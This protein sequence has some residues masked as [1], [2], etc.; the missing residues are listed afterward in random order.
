MRAPSVK[1]M[2]IVQCTHIHSDAN[3]IY[4]PRKFMWKLLNIYRTYTIVR[5][6]SS[7]RLKSVYLWAIF[8]LLMFISRKFLSLA[9]NSKGMF[10]MHNEWVMRTFKPTKGISICCKGNEIYDRLGCRLAQCEFYLPELRSLVHQDR[11]TVI[12]VHTNVCLVWN[13]L[14]SPCAYV[15]VQRIDWYCSVNLFPVVTASRFSYFNHNRLANI[16]FTGYYFII[17]W[18]LWCGFYFSYFFHLLFFMHLSGCFL[19]GLGLLAFFTSMSMSCSIKN[20][21]LKWSNH[22]RSND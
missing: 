3:I 6:C 15:W 8:M 5:W 4:R 12:R 7:I 14:V 2:Y 18:L 13:S 21:T 16:T 22:N 9:P 20:A 11:Q 1:Y 17:N 19:C 10:W